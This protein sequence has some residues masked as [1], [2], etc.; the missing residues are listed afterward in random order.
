MAALNDKTKI[1]DIVSG[2]M[3]RYSTAVAVQEPAC[4]VPGNLALNADEEVQIVRQR[5][6]AAVLKAPAQGP[7]LSLYLSL[8]LCLY[9]FL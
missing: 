6:I 2:M 4:A 8:Y 7:C 3:I 5:G 1:A 9:L